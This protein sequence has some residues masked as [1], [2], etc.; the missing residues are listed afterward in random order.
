[1]LSPLLDPDLRVHAV[2]KSLKAQELVAELPVE[3]FVGGILPRLPRVD[4]R[5]VNA[6]VAQPA[7]DRGGNEPRSVARPQVARGAVHADE[8]GE[9]VQRDP[10]VAQRTGLHDVTPCHRRRPV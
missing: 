1:M 10:A 7:Q 9:Q 4:Q 3:R 2:P 5:R 8:L 6:S